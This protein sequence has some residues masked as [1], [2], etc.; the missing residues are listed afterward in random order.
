MEKSKQLM[1]MPNNGIVIYLISVAVLLFIPLIVMQFTNEVKWTLMDFV[2][3]AVLLLGTGLLCA[4]VI[5]KVN[6]ISHRIAICASILVLLLLVWA[7]L[8]VGIL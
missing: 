3:A 7:Q 6:K 8:A 1:I 5:K 2:A 4:F